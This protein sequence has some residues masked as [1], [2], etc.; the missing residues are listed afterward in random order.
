M[1]EQKRDL[2]TL[3]D[4]VTDIAHQ[5]GNDWF[6]KELSMKLTSANE[7]NGKF[8]TSDS[9]IL[10]DLKRS[11]FY[12][13]SIDKTIW[14]EALKYYK[15]IKYSDLKMELLVDYK[16]MK[17]ADKSDDVIEYTRRIV[18]QLENCLNA[19]CI[20]TKAHEVIKLNPEMYKTAYSDLLTGEYAFFNFDKSEKSLAKISLQ[21]KLFFAKQRYNIKYPFVEMS[22][23]IIIRNK[24]SH[25]GEYTEKEKEILDKAKSNLSET[26]AKYFL[27]F[28]NFWNK[29][30]DLTK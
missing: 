22:E 10:Q 29:M 2:K 6:K 17:I 14:L 20:I 30:D 21:S 24:S 27:C 13:K 7:I 28:N 18:M 8:E 23:M 15:K 1:D 26:K 12:L 19:I 5:K 25:R 9:Q 16:E 4:F 11:K 3:I